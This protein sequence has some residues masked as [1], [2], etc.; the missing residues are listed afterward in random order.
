ML[1]EAARFSRPH[2]NVIRLLVLQ[3]QLEGFRALDWKI[4]LLICAGVGWKA[5]G[6]GATHCCT[7]VLL[8]QG[9]STQRAPDLTGNRNSDWDVHVSRPGRR[10]SLSL[11]SNPKGRTECGQAALTC[12]GR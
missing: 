5:C 3:G 4:M 11:L 9:S 6:V 10:Q 8:E 2:E 12:R 1:T 7:A